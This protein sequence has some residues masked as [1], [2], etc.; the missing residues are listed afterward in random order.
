[1]SI[2]TA[3]LKHFYQRRTLWLGYIVLGLFAFAAIAI[4]LD[5]PEAGEGTFVGFNVVALLLGLL[6][7]VM[8]MEIMTRPFAFGLPGHRQ[9]VRKFIFSVAIVTNA[10]GSLIFLF[11]P[12][13]SVLQ[14][15]LVICSA[16][17]TGMVFYLAG[18][19]WAL[20]VNQPMAFIGFAM[21]ALFLGQMLNLHVW[22][23]TAIVDYPVITIPLGILCSIIVWLRL[24]DSSL[25][26]R[27]CQM[28]WIGFD[29]FN[30]EKIRKGQTKIAANRWKQLKDHPRP[31][32]ENL[33]INTMNRQNP[34]SSARALWGTLYTAF[35]VP[36]SQWK[37]GVWFCLFMAV[38]LGYFGS[39]MWIVL[40]G[41]PILALCQSRPVIYSHMLT[42][43]GRR[44]RFHS[45]L[46]LGF[47]GAALIA[48]VVAVIV[49]MSTL[50]NTFMPD[51]DY[52]GLTRPYGAVNIRV[53][54]A[55]LV[56][57]PFAYAVF[58]L[59]YRKTVAAVVVFMMVYFATV[60]FVVM[61]GVYATFRSALPA[62]CVAILSW[63]IFVFV[64]HRVSARYC[65]VK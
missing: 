42:A 35:G 62:T 40:T 58:L 44:E 19:F 47:A 41:I 11:Y 45:T 28:P 55:P 43:G 6:A 65:L 59:L 17:F 37:R 24:D 36:I 26:R 31:W 7:A 60:W 29:S 10:I 30:W 49:L 34:L 14:V 1:M 13:L 54:Y 2:L 23:E 33:F 5:A 16:F 64:S 12:G 61:T 48:L 18:T 21:C 8:Q 25:A 53:L 51:I 39:R 46:V 9:M 32:I 3:N 27:N 63:L 52:H 20:G 57:L 50:L 22:L 38:F 4:P 56:V 15:P